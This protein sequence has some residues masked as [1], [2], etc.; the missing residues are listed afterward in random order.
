MSWT[1]K[2]VGELLK[3]AETGAL[4]PAEFRR[5]AAVGALEPPRATWLRAADR[6]LLFGGALLLATAIIFFFAYN[7][8]DM[9]RFVKLALAIA[10]LA[11]CA[12]IAFAS[13]VFGTAW[14]AAL[15]G[16]ALLTGALLALI[17]QTYQTG[18]D[19]WEL[20]AAW[21]LLMLP[22]ALLARSSA[23]WGLWLAVAN[24]ALL[25]ALSERVF[26]GLLTG[27]L[28]WSGPLLV[29]AALNL[30]VLLAFELRGSML[31]VAPRRHIARLAA[32]IMLA[33]LA[34]G[35]IVGWWE[36]DLA[37]V[38]AAYT[39]TATGAGWY[40]LARRRDLLILAAATFSAIAVLTS[41]LIRVLPAEAG[42]VVMNLIAIF[43]IA[44]SA[45]AGSWIV[46]LHR[47]AQR[48]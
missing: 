12:G 13:R 44:A 39:L 42:F 30:L 47:Q 19:I 15:L 8:A 9:H 3:L 24:L 33:V 18:A 5:A 29:I 43:V 36:R 34:G 41:A 28:E 1:A 31:L 17:G 32:T 37:P 4:S 48:L 11:A 10:A 27:W 23:A 45:I 7:W 20:F 16:A 26:A 2:Q 21:T 25:R 38:T 35:A 6:L 22:F 14:R 40:Y 46:K